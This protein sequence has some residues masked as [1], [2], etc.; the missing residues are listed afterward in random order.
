MTP[1][2]SAAI[3]FLMSPVLAYS[4]LSCLLVLGISIFILPIQFNLQQYYAH[5]ILL[6]AIATV[7]IFFH[8]PVL[9]KII[10]ETSMKQFSTVHQTR[11]ILIVFMAIFLF[12][13]LLQPL[14]HIAY[15]YS[16]DLPLYDTKLHQL[17][18]MFGL[19]WFAYFNWVH[20][21]P[22]IIPILDIAYKSM[23][24]V[25]PMALTILMLFHR[26][27]RA[28]VLLHGFLITALICLMIG[29]FFPA[30][31]ATTFLIGDLSL[32]PNFQSMPG[33]YAVSAIEHLRTTSDVITFDPREMPG[34]VTFPSF[35]TAG[36]IAIAFA[37]RRTALEIPMWIYT[38]VVVASTPVFGAHYLIDLCA[39]AAIAFAVCTVV[40]KWMYLRRAAYFPNESAPAG[41][42]YNSPV[43]T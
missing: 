26:T 12:M 9:A 8:P 14:C 23:N 30:L 37:F 33:S 39:G 34:L 1:S 6:T 7:V 10:S 13:L 4:L 3:K 41:G 18:T 2:T 19:D 11:D 20:D 27:D 25:L 17:D 40:E 21:N 15:I 38:I 5:I 22:I 35:H 29:A 28:F 36:T 32:F 42:I 16:K 24:L 43:T 31:G